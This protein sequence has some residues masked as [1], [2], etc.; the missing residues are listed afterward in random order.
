M[1]AVAES[2]DLLTVGLER[3]AEVR[4]TALRGAW[5]LLGRGLGCTPR[6]S[7]RIGVCM[8]HDREDARDRGERSVRIP[9]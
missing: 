3:G 2:P 9:W 1:R 6:W 7:L 5:T 8:G 4:S